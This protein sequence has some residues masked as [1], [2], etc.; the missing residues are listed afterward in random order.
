MSDKL[1]IL[2]PLLF[3]ISEPGRIAV[4][5][6]A[7]DVPQMLLGDLLPADALRYEIGL[8]ELSEPEV[9]RHFTHLSRENY[10]VD[11]GFYPLGSCTMKYNPKINEEAAR[12]P[13]FSRLHPYL[14]SHRST[15]RNGSSIRDAADHD[16][17]RR[18]GCLLP[19]AR[20]RSTW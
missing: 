8:P 13:G 14:P 1:G 15:R 3:E 5:L 4:E 20:S 18:H 16:R 6:P 19:A 10:S 2:E 7:C 9:I 17:D 11:L 12:Q